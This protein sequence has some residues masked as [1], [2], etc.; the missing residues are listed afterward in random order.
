M[1]QALAAERRCGCMV[2]GDEKS[3][4]AEVRESG[5]FDR[6][7]AVVSLAAWWT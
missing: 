4:A 1:G 7:A 5:S 3:A 2:A 6:V